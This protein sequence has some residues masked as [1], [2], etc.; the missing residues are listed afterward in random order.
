MILNKNTPPIKTLTLFFIL[1]LSYAI[2]RYHIFGGVSWDQLPLYVMNKVFSLTVVL[3]LFY[4]IWFSKVLTTEQREWYTCAIA[5]LVLVHVLISIS[6]LSPEYYAKFFDAGKM[7]FK[8]ELSILF[9]I[10]A[11]IAFIGLLLGSL[12]GNIELAK[13]FQQ[14]I[15]FL[16]AV[17]L[18][19]MG[20]SGWI[21]PFKWYGAMPPISLVS[22]MVV[23]A[24][25]FTKRRVK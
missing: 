2:L 8:S 17:H 23:L 25:V 21:T 4:K 9:G 5:V 16:L 12:K 6:L 14:A 13:K 15:L 10:A 11:F 1:S 20:F 18:F 24:I 7:H 3:L 19:S 22:F